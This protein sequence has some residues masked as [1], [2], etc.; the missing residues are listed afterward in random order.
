MAADRHPLAG[1]TGVPGGIAGTIEGGGIG[2]STEGDRHGH[3]PREGLPRTH[4][5]RGG[6]ASPPGGNHASLRPLRYARRRMRRGVTS[7][8]GTRWRSRASGRYQT[9]PPAARRRCWKSMSSKVPRWS[10]RRPTV[11]FQVPSRSKTSAGTAM[12]APHRNS[13]DA[14]ARSSSPWSRPGPS[15]ER[16]AGDNHEGH[17]DRSGGAGSIAPPAMTRAFVR[18]EE[19]TERFHPAGSELHVVVGEQ[20]QGTCG[21]RD[22]GVHR[23]A[24]PEPLFPYEAEPVVPSGPCT[25]QIRR[26]VGGGVVD[27]DH[28][29]VG[30]RSLRCDRGERGP[31]H[32][33]SV[34]RRHDDADRGHDP[35]SARTAITM[36]Y[37]GSRAA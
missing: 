33:G 23:A 14:S 36:G 18:R 25:E 2:A 31:Q 19:P 29:E 21:D 6:R 1:P 4:D 32:L 27:D 26:A 22:P 34:P 3:P 15:A 8:V 20:Q 37:A 35:F 30:A 11:S 5:A 9:E 10:P 24:P 17:D 12:L 28:L 16:D 13:W 7:A